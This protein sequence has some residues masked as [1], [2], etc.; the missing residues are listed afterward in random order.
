[1]LMLVSFSLSSSLSFSLILMVFALDLNTFSSF[2]FIS[3]F[4]P[5]LFLPSLIPSVKNK[6]VY[7]FKLRFYLLSSTHHA[8]FQFSFSVSADLTVHFMQLSLSLFDLSVCPSVSYAA[9]ES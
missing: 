7:M 3:S 1:M 4:C 8:S 6:S 2:F 5:S 9:R